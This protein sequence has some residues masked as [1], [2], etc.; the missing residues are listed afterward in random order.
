MK[1]EQTYVSASISD[2]KRSHYIMTK[3]LE[4]YEQAFDAMRKAIGN[5]E[6]TAYL[7]IDTEE[8][9]ET[10]RELFFELWKKNPH[11][12]V[13]Y[14]LAG[15]LKDSDRGN[16]RAAIRIGGWWEDIQELRKKFPIIPVVNIG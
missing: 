16:T 2:I 9:E 5:F 12:E 13:G 14:L 1:T 10:V 8:Y 3:A 7:N 6:G 11:L 15:N 4:L